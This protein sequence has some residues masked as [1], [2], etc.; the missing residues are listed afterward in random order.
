MSLQ[1]HRA[2]ETMELWIANSDGFS[3]VISFERTTG[4]GFHGRP[5]YVASWRPL[6]ETKG[7][8]KI[9]G[10]PFK[11]F[12]EAEEACNRMLEHLSAE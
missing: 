10:S 4:P 12:G 11:T 8:I 3:F 7:A 1:F 9:S 5:G 2:V 6:Y